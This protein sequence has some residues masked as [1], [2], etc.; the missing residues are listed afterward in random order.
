MV[1]MREAV[2]AAVVVTVVVIC[3]YGQHDDFNGLVVV[4]NIRREVLLEIQTLS[5]NV[6]NGE[7]RVATPVNLSRKRIN[8]IVIMQDHFSSKTSLM[9]IW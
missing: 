5:T 2:V 8:K 3:C 6:H 9:L 7:A 4:G 1:A